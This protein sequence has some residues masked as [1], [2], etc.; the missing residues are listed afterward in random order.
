[1]SRHVPPRDPSWSCPLSRP[2]WANHVTFTTCYVSLAKL[3]F[4]TPWSHIPPSGLTQA[5]VKSS[6]KPY[7]WDTPSK[8]TFWRNTTCEW[9]RRVP[10]L[11][12]GLSGEQRSVGQ[13]PLS[14]CIEAARPIWVSQVGQPIP[15]QGRGWSW[16]KVILALQGG[17]F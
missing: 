11:L 15:Y 13:P 9:R 10:K 14:Q 5:V 12:R 3:P 2:E 6:A 1:M 4:L 8:H 17:T 16:F 7:H